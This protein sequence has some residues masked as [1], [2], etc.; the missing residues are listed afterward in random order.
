METSYILG[1]IDTDLVIVRGLPGSGKSTYAKTFE[2][3]IIIEAD[4]WWY[5]NKNLEYQFDIEKL[6]EAHRWALQTVEAL[7]ASGQDVAI[8]NTNLAFKEAKGYIKFAKSIGC[9]IRVHTTNKEV[10]YGSIHGVP[11]EVMNRMYNKMEDHSTFVEK[12]REYQPD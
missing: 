6:H 10:N 5:R 9:N 2:D 12:I 3:T 8:V 7:L 4:M 11:S 1:T